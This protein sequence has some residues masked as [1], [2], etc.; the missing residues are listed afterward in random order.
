MRRSHA[1]FKLSVAL[2]L[3]HIVHQAVQLPLRIHFA[4][5][6]KRKSIQSLGAA[7]VAEHRLDEA[8]APT[9]LVSTDLAV[10]LALHLV[11]I[12][13]WLPRHEPAKEHNLS[14][15]RAIGVT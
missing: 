7:D 10:D 12:F 3:L 15:G 11:E 5:A 2:D 4:S 9:V 1:L 14:I 6:A 8:Q 13:F